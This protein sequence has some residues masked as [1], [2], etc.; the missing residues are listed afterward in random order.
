MFVYAMVKYWTGTIHSCRAILLEGYKSGLA[1]GDLERASSKI[2][3]YL[4]ISF[5][6]E[7]SLKS[8]QM[9]TITYGEDFTIT[10]GE[11]FKRFSLQR[12]C[13]VLQNIQNGV[14]VLTWERAA[15]EL[16]SYTNVATMEEKKSKDIGHVRMEVVDNPNDEL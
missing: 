8:L 12:A 6:T 15:G 13:D 3:Q 11:D 2:V 5:E 7:V 9:V 1:V 4:D 10:Y 16:N 14:S